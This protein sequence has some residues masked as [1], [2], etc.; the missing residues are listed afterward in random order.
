M[1]TELFDIDENAFEPYPQSFSAA[2]QSLVLQDPFSSSP[3]STIAETF[4]QPLS[5]PFPNMGVNA[6]ANFVPSCLVCG[7]SGDRLVIIEPCKH[8]HCN[9]CFTSA[10][11]IV[12]EK[13][14]ECA[15]CKALVVSFAFRHVADYE[16]VKPSV[17]CQPNHFPALFDVTASP[18]LPCS[19]RKDSH[20]SPNT[21]HSKPLP[22]LMSTM[23]L[24]DNTYD[25][26]LSNPVRKGENIV[27]RIDNVPWVSIVFSLSLCRSSILRIS[28][29]P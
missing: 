3:L 13:D 26:G 9:A 22:S 4:P 5:P 14:M 24:Y 1:P 27:L 11:N 29:P 18:T 7:R 8:A 19:L 20:T 17:N 23:S 16:T 15:V 12:G 2:A 25:L 10:L 21:L 28:R 6:A